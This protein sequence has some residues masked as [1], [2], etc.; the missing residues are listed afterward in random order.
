MERKQKNQYFNSLLHLNHLRDQKGV[1][2]EQY[3]VTSTLDLTDEQIDALIDRLQ[4][5]NQYKAAD[6]PK[7]IRRLRS[8]LIAE[9]EQYLGVKMHNKSAWERLNGLLL[10]PKI[11]GKMM[12]EMTEAELKTT[13]SRLCIINKKQKGKADKENTIA[14]LN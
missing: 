11:A 8:C 2:L 5:L 7:K 12:V 1:L 13:V 3:G 10:S 9:C 4:N 6:V 14:V